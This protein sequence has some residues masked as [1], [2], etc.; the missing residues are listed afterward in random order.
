M[1]VPTA[2]A[3]GRDELRERLLALARARRENPSPAPEDR[4]RQAVEA[5]LA[6]LETEL[7]LRKTNLGCA[8]TDDEYAA[9]SG[10]F[11]P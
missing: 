11:R 4:E 8:K 9:I 1:S 3:G 5:K 6:G 2:L 10:Q 7:E